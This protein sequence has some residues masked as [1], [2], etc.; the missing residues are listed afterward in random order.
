MKC[1]S[2]AENI[3]FSIADLFHE[4]SEALKVLTDKKAKVSGK[5]LFKLIFVVCPN[6]HIFM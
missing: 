2:M 3:Q 6:F 1:F 5:F 4:L